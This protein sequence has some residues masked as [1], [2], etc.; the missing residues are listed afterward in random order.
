MAV[1]ENLNIHSLIAVFISLI[2][3]FIILMEWIYRPGKLIKPI[4]HRNL[5]RNWFYFGWLIDIRNENQSSAGKL[6]TRPIEPFSVVS[7][8]INRQSRG[9]KNSFVECFDEKFRRIE[10]HS[11]KS[12]FVLCVV[13]PPRALLINSKSARFSFPLA[14]AAFF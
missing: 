13:R 4:K 9:F 8:R 2:E 14:V 3:H 10:M 6:P 1:I 5:A 12:V 11:S 7:N